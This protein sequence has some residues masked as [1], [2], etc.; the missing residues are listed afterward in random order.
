M[1]S[2]HFSGFNKLP[3]ICDSKFIFND[4]FKTSLLF[5]K[6]TNHKCPTL[7]LCGGR[8][9]PAPLE[10]LFLDAPTPFSAQHF[11]KKKKEKK[12]S[13]VH[14]AGSCTALTSGALS[15]PGCPCCTQECVSGATPES[16]VHYTR[17][18]T[19]SAHKRG[20]RN[21]GLAYIYLRSSRN[22]AVE[23]KLRPKQAR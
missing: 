2:V 13:L 23:N 11:H 4:S 1:P 14:R 21:D 8:L 15:V 22:P 10:S 17:P 5:K 3:R 9:S 16:P 12:V 19:T 20:Y 18:R 6:Y 7:R